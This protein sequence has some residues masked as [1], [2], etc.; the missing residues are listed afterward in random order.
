MKEEVQE[1]KKELADVKEKSLAMELLEDERKASKRFF[2]MWV[3]TFLAF[4]GLLGYTI[5]LLNDISTIETSTQEITD[6]ES[7][8]GNII[9]RGNMYGDN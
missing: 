5:Y 3:I 4:L 6:F 1:I 2:I 7:I 9:N 8:D